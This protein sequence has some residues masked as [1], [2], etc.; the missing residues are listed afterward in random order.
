MNRFKQHM[1]SFV[2]IGESPE[3]IEFDTIEDLLGLEI[4]QRYGKCKDFSHFAL[5]EN[6]LLEISDE[7]FYWWVV[8]YIENP[9]AV[10]LPQWKGKYRAELPDGSK[11]ILTDEV[12]SSCGD[13][14]TLRDGTKAKNLSGE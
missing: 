4:V 13:I 6:H 7:G 2:D 3:W 12:I 10:D 1:P 9:S 14:L 8:G 11:V 5:N